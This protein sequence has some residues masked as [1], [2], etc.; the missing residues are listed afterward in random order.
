MASKCPDFPPFVLSKPFHT[1]THTH[2]CLHGI[3]T[4]CPSCWNPARLP[5]HLPHEHALPHLSLPVTQLSPDR[6]A[7]RSPGSCPSLTG[8]ETLG[9]DTSSL[10]GDKSTRVSSSLRLL[11]RHGVA[12]GVHLLLSLE[13]VEAIW[14]SSCLH[15]DV[16]VWSLCLHMKKK[17][18]IESI[19][20]TMALTQTGCIVSI[21]N[22]VQITT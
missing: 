2:S 14:G 17:Q 21:S 9:G 6:A 11:D 15:I 16:H 12:T 4:G 19:C 10:C 20:K 1:Q 13:T 3:S 7:L 5:P 18:Y 22:Y 8:A